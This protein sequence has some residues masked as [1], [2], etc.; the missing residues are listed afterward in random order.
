MEN[1]LKPGDTVELPIKEKFKESEQLPLF[2]N[3]QK[4]WEKEWQGMPEFIQND[5]GPFKSVIVHFENRDD[6]DAFSK[7]VEQ[8]ITQDTASI[9]FPKVETEGESDKS[10]ID[11]P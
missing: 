3:L 10:Y 6:M 5:I 9:W 2:D 11:E 4:D 7:V 8:N 1:E